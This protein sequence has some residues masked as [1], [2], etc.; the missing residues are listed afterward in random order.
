M[1]LIK[2]METLTVFFVAIIE[3]LLLH[4]MHLNKNKPMLEHVQTHE[5]PFSRPIAKGIS[6]S[7]MSYVPMIY[8]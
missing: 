1:G 6:W 4:D 5:I 2:I 3:Q 7:D 8:L